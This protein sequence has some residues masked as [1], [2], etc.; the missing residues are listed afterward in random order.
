MQIL[1]VF[2]RKTSLTPNDDMAVIGDPGLF[3]PPADEV[4]VS[5]VFSW[6]ITEGKR[7]R[8]A[9][10]QHYPI[11]KIGGPA[12]GNVQ[13]SFIPGMYIRHGVTFT[14]RGCNNHCPWCQVPEREGKLI[15]IRDFAEGWII[16][17]NNL[18]QASRPH[19]ERV[20]SMLQN[21][22]H[23]AVFSGGLQASL[24]DDWFVEQLRT[25]RLESVFLAADTIGA[26]RPLEKALNKLT[27]FDRRKLRV[28][29]MIGKDE[30]IE[31]SK[32]R[33]Q[34]IWEMGGLPFAQLYQPPERYINYAH[35]WKVLVREW[36]RPAAM[37]SV[38]KQANTSSSGQS[39]QHHL[40]L[41]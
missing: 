27:A 18:L 24:L 31:Q 29:C 12:F 14:T 38:Q 23:A 35:E 16:Q 28:Y 7:L 3:L 15:E 22:K 34:A 39:E 4:H 5:V 19:I 36:S 2:P 13:D 37:F 17:D 6:D 33:L 10:A 21:Q 9:W 20:F 41:S 40:P 25:I 11:V 8:S 32:N 30:T 1:R 26:L